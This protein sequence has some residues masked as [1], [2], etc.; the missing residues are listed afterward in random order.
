[1]IRNTLGM[2]PNNPGESPNTVGPVAINNFETFKNMR[3]HSNDGPEKNKK[4]K[5][6]R[7]ESEEEHSSDGSVQG[8][9]NQAKI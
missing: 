6:N 8:Q 1:M 4:L 5:L 9:F 7:K 3:R 2:S